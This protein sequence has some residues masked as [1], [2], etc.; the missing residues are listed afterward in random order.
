MVITSRD[1]LRRQAGGR[2]GGDSKGKTVSWTTAVRNV[3]N[4]GQGEEGTG[5]GEREGQ[6][7][8]LSSFAAH[9][10]N[11]EATAQTAIARIQNIY[12]TVSNVDKYREEGAEWVLDPG[13]SLR[14]QMWRRRGSRRNSP[15]EN[16]QSTLLQSNS[17]G[18]VY[19]GSCFSA[20]NTAG[21]VPLQY[22]L[23][24]IHCYL[25]QRHRRLI[26]ETNSF[27]RPFWREFVVES[28]PPTSLLSPEEWDQ[29]VR[30]LDVNMITASWAG[31]HAASLCCHYARQP[32]A[33]HA[34]RAFSWNGFLRTRQ[35]NGSLCSQK[36]K[37]H[38][39]TSQDLLV[40]GCLGQLA[41]IRGL[42]KIHPCIS[43]IFTVE[44]VHYVTWQLKTQRAALSGKC[45][46]WQRRGWE[47]TRRH[48]KK[49]SRLAESY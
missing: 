2:A 28:R 46:T 17:K 1:I 36:N 44:S 33:P 49:Q 32:L 7:H 15:F 18:T 27:F 21:A 10:T 39:K 4:Q 3:S 31:S 42:I 38:L 6:R 40:K 23:T 48:Q 35:A 19:T 25:W 43:F 14:L 29:W 24:S 13:G 11:V 12:Q 41:T 20:D 26:P 8:N 22:I 37:K 30:G 16:K 5:S 47:R 45:V 34:F 9:F